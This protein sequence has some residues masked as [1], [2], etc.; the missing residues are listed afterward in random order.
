MK[1]LAIRST[2]EEKILQYK[3]ENIK[4]RAEGLKELDVDEV[5]NKS[6][7]VC[8]LLVVYAGYAS[9]TAI[10]KDPKFITKAVPPE[11]NLLHIK[12]FTD[13]AQADE[14]PAPDADTTAAGPSTPDDG[15][16]TDDS[17]ES[18]EPGPRRRLSGYTHRLGT[19]VIT[20]GPVPRPDQSGKR[21][22]QASAASASSGTNGARTTKRLRV[23][24]SGEEV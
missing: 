12:L 4:R 6:I 11:E 13:Q 3:D 14:P 5:L 2:A 21:R 1:T 18:G 9:L 8:T 22:R 24:F 20:T 15:S 23:L 19:N 17:S 7:A 10:F 16:Q